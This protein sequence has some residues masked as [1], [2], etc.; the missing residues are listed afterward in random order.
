MDNK[1][2][3]LVDELAA[4]ENELVSVD[5]ILLKPSQ[6]YRFE[7]DPVHLMFNTNCPDGLKKKV[8][9]ILQKHLPYEAG[10]S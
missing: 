1:L 3:H 4:L 5:G 6:C 8:Q 10:S 7:T 2:K 9:A